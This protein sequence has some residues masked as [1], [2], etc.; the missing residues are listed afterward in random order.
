LAYYFAIL[1]LR[2]SP[3]L[4]I[5]TSTGFASKRAQALSLFPILA[6]NQS[7]PESVKVLRITNR[8]KSRMDTMRINCL[9]AFVLMA[10]TA[11]AKVQNGGP[12]IETQ[13]YFVAVIVRDLDASIL[14]YESLFRL[15]VARRESVPDRRIRMAILESSNLLIELIED[16]S[17]LVRT[18]LLEKSPEGTN[19]Q[20]HF[21]VGFKVHNMDAFLKR[22]KVLKIDVGRVYSDSASKKRNFLMKDPDGNLIQFFE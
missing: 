9:L 11:S 12:A 5:R 8:L 16:K 15:S 6:A 18:Q 13:P 21:K 1:P 7:V 10:I 20:G 17:A 22:L 2:R 3:Y 4:N 19:I 14:W